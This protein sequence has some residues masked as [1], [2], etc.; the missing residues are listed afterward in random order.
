MN[1][2]FIILILLVPFFLIKDKGRYKVKNLHTNKL[3]LGRSLL[4][5]RAIEDR[6]MSKLNPIIKQRFPNT[7]KI[8]FMNIYV[9]EREEEAYILVELK[10]MM[11]NKTGFNDL[12]T[13]IQVEC[14]YYYGPDELLV[15]TLLLNTGCYDTGAIIP[16]NSDKYFDQH[17]VRRSWEHHKRAWDYISALWKAEKR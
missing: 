16:E 4:P 6:I 2:L 7:R 11:S 5:D 13:Q 12:V 8:E 15:N 10:L 9:K 14:I 1:I 3:K 17:F